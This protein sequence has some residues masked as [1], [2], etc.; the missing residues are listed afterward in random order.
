MSA[1]NAIVYAVTFGMGRI[2]RHFSECFFGTAL[3]LLIIR[4]VSSVERTNQAAFYHLI[5]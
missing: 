3:R 4:K 5:F 1:I 2:S